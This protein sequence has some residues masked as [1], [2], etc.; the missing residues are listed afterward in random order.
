MQRCV[1]KSST[2]YCTSPH[3]SIFW[4]LGWDSR[5]SCCRAMLRPTRTQSAIIEI[6]GK[7]CWHLLLQCFRVIL[8]QLLVGPSTCSFFILFWLYVLPLIYIQGNDGKNKL[9]LGDRKRR[10]SFVLEFWKES[11]IEDA[12][13]IYAVYGFYIYGTWWSLFGRWEDDQKQ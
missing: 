1:I 7:G 6:A 9:L 11:F 10:K 8:L 2:S 4:V 3:R 12:Y 5:I 13:G